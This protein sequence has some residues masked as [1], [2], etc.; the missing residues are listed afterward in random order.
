M[1]HK[2]RIQ[3]QND[4][5]NAAEEAIGKLHSNA[6]HIVEDLNQLR[7]KAK[8]IDAVETSFFSD[9]TKMDP[10][11]KVNLDNVTS[12]ILENLEELCRFFELYKQYANT[13]ER[14]Y[15]TARSSLPDSQE[16]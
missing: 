3:I 11:E 7:Q 16:K 1:D 13:V 2:T 9:V 5:I 4:C 14:R 12:S 8:I 10:I 6:E 15:E